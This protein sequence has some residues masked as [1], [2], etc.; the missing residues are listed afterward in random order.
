LNVKGF[1][2]YGDV[3][4]KIGRVN[5]DYKTSLVDSGKVSQADLDAQIEKIRSDIGVSDV[6]PTVSVGASYIF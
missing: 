2:I 1:G 5:I 4:F 6:L 3:G